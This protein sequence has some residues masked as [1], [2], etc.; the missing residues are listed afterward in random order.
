MGGNAAKRLYVL[1]T[2]SPDAQA[3][4][5]N[6]RHGW[7][8]KDLDAPNIFPNGARSARIDHMPGTD[9]PFESSWR[10]YFDAGQYPSPPNQ[11]VLHKF[12][13]LWN[14]NVV[15]AKHRLHSDTLVQVD[16]K[17]EQFADVILTE[18][19]TVKLRLMRPTKTSVDG[20][21]Q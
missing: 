7:D 11:C 4:S 1:G 21:K 10:I 15:L 19:V 2:A 13:V 18:Q 5:I 14:G 8:D 12:G 16:A 6:T 17:E 3:M 20:S 9:T